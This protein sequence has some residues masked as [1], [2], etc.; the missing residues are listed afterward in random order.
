[1]NHLFAPESKAWLRTSAFLTSLIAVIVIYPFL[2]DSLAGKLIASL[3]ILLTL[4]GGVAAM[5]SHRHAMM[6]TIAIV[7]ISVIIEILSYLF[8]GVFFKSVTFMR[9]FF[10]NLFFA[11]L[12]F[13]YLLRVEQLTM[14]DFGNAVSVYLLFGLAFANLYCFIVQ[15]YPQAFSFPNSTEIVP[16]TDLVYYS[17]VTLTT[18]GYGDIYPA[19]KVTKVLANIESIFGVFYIA[20]IIGRMVGAGIKKT[21][22]RD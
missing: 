21:L 19:M 22:P 9:S 5:F 1:M 14:V 20:V 15:F 17:F 2:S 8:P 18:T 6:I 4:A 7:V 10:V 12:L 13:Y 11:L 16:Q 3:L